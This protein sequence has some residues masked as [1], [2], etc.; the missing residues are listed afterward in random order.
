MPFNEADTRAKLIDPALHDAGWSEDWIRREQ[1]PG[2]VIRLGA[3][4][5]RGAGFTDY[6]L[7]VLIKGRRYPIALVEA[8]SEDADPAK[9]LGQAKR[10]ARKH[11][12]PFAFSS[13]G[14]QF[15]EA[16]LK[17]NETRG[18]LPMSKF[19]KWDDLRDRWAELGGIDIEAEPSRPLWTAPRDGARYYQKA[20]RRAALEA[21]ARGENRILLPLATGAGKTWIAVGILAALDGA[22]QLG[23]ALFLCDRDKL[24]SQALGALSGHFGTDAAAATTKQPEHNARVIVAT[25][26]TL[27]VDSEDGTA[28]FLTTHYPQNYF[29]HII[30]DEC[31]R[32]AWGK[33]SQVLERNPDAVQIGLTATPREIDTGDASDVD[34][35]E[36]NEI[37]ANNYK[38][39]GNPVYEYS[40]A[41]GMDDG[42]LAAMEVARSDV[43]T[44]G[45]LDRMEGVERDKLKGA[46][47]A[48]A[49]TGAPAG[50]YDLRERYGAGA[51][52]QDIRLPERVGA[53]CDD[54]FARLVDSGGPEQKTLIFCASIAHA[55]AVIQ[56]MNNRYAAWCEERGSEPIEPYGFTCTA[57]SGRELL[58]PFVG[59]MRRAFVAA[60]VDLVSTGVDVPCL[61][62]VV[63]F[64]YLKSPILFHQMLGR[65]TRIHELSGKLH[66]TVYDYTDAARL[67]DASL[68]QRPA[69]PYE[70]SG[71][72][73]DPVEVYR[74]ENVNVKIERGEH[75][76]AVPGSDGK[77]EFLS[78]REYGER[79]A[80]GL[81]EQTAALTDFRNHWL[82]PEQRVGLLARLADRGLHASAYR[83]V[84]DLHD[85][86]LYDILAELGWGETIRTRV[87]RAE[88][89]DGWIDEQRSAASILRV[90]ARQFGAAGT[91]ALESPKLFDV[92]AV[93]QAG[94]IDALQDGSV[95]ELKR[96]LLATD[97]EWAA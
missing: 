84:A 38:Y 75:S 23:R 4:D 30:I 9:G 58:A 62:N 51:L 45:T 40:I 70:P 92:P 55:N 22:K 52:E 8:K 28:S 71:D 77:L 32:S 79:I 10:D 37:T 46:V 53:M 67:L 3:T 33:W 91:E 43:W 29:S 19:P 15:V 94:G 35:A 24:R 82:Q 78:L 27:G 56:A 93:K 20:A 86:D 80:A 26:Q 83:S 90:L 2:P 81:L 17:T 5:T 60:T 49:V 72:S 64:R 34:A 25:Y 74:V 76:I 47:V 66:F 16:N 42:Y 50:T 6:L 36:D 63:F 21:I 31:H 48:E 39:F 54:L 89:I 85:S 1:S 7:H 69:Q 44:A 57:E 12:V 95:L 59:N 11:H 97:A 18:P 88:H 73:A 13:N 96:R 41:Q 14:H 61:Q 68:K 87:E 65:G